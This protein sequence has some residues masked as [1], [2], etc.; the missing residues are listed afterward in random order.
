MSGSQQPASAP[1]QASDGYIYGTTFGNFFPDYG[2]IYQVGLDGTGTALY[3][4]TGGA[5]SATPFGGIIQNVDGNLYGTTYGNILAGG[6]GTVYRMPLGGGSLYTLYNFT[7]GADG[8]HP[9]GSLAP[10]TSGNLYGTTSGGGSNGNGSIFKLGL[11]GTLTPLVDLTSSEGSNATAPPILGSDGNWYGTT[12][13]G[14]ANSNGIVYQLTPSGTLNVLHTFSGNGDGGAPQGALIEGPDGNFYG[15]TSGG[16]ATAADGVNGTF[17]KIT[18]AGVLTTVHVFNGTTDGQ[19]PM[20]VV[21]ASDGNFYGA[22]EVGGANGDGVVFEITPSGNLTTLYNLGASSTDG[23]YPQAGVMQASDGNIYGTTGQGGANSLGTVFK[24]AMSP[25]LPAP[26]QVTPGATQI[27]LG[28]TV[29]LNWSVLNAFSQ[30]MQVCFASVTPAVSSAGAWSGVQTG[31]YSS[32]TQLYTGSATLTPTLPGVYTY[33]LTCGGV[34]SGFA[35]VTVGDAA[36]LEFLTTTLPPV[37][38]GQSYSQTLKVSGGVKPYTFS[39]TAG[40]MPAGLTLNVST[41]VISGQPTGSGM[42]AFTVTVADSDPVQQS[43]ANESLSIDVVQPLSIDQSG[44]LTPARIGTAYSM[45]LT[46]AGGTAPYTWAIPS[47]SLPAGLT[48]SSSGLISGT[49]TAAATSA[50][51]VSAIDSSTVDQQVASAQLSLTVL[52]LI[53]TTG[54]LT[55]TPSSISL[56]QTTVATVNLTEPA[57]SPMPTGTVQ[58]QSNGAN[59]GSP[60]PLTNGSATLTTPAFNATG[61]LAITANYSGDANY[62]NLTYQPVTLTV[63]PVPQ[64][65]VT[66]IPGSVTLT[67]G[68]STVL[69][70]T[71]ANFGGAIS[72]TCGNLPANTTCEFSAASGN[73]VSQLNLVAAQV[74]SAKNGAPAIGRGPAGMALAAGIP[75]LFAIGGLAWR[76]RWSRVLSLCALLGVGLL[77]SACGGSS[78]PPQATPGTSLVTVTATAGQQTAVTEFT[79]TVAQ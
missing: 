52:P 25:A 3:T 27:P 55:L 26:V 14:G 54:T 20:G 7:G 19:G 38:A 40:S 17:F 64:P 71:T 13:S 35:T 65:S 48:M 46:A 18:P 51:A 66:V 79:F 74:N 53:S 44:A 78:K 24:L 22:T 49:A 10:D 31:T 70:V 21:L 23:K 36:T 76:R 50:F 58:F 30:T 12:F 34:E 59:I 62:L 61:S 11:T 72:F 4:F 68:A 5:D 57:G 6:P 60:V 2:G 56:G 43:T 16:G 15:I 28:G 47:G 33:A 73:G 32:T 45:Q 29:T 37:V 42:S 69:V 9:E 41:G 75:L 1:I 39:V 63:S 67:P 8:E 77:M